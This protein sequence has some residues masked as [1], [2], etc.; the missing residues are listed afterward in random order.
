VL[1][2]KVIVSNPSGQGVW[3]QATVLEG[4]PWL[5]VSPSNGTAVFGAPAELIL[6]ADTR[7]LA[8]GSYFGR[9]QLTALTPAGIA[10]VDIPVQLTVAADLTRVFAPLSGRDFGRAW[11]DPDTA[12]NLYRFEPNVTNDGLAQI[13]LPFL[14]SF[15]GAAFPAITVSENGLV[16]FGQGNA[17]VQAPSTCPGNG[18]GPNN[19]LYVLAA[20][21]VVDVGASVIVH[22]PNADTFVVTWR[23]ARLNGSEARGTFQLVITRGGEFRANYRD[24]AGAAGAVIGS[25]NDDGTASETIYCQGHGLIPPATG[26]LSFNPRAPWQ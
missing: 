7:S 12:D 13:V 18:A 10:P 4:A 20:D 9:V 3:W 15:Y 25:E 24:P 16:A 17:P 22:Y 14:V 26:T 21:W 2:R 19:A 1:Q 5:A 8:P 6:V 11:Y 23:D